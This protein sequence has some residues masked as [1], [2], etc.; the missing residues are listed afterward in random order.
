MTVGVLHGPNL[1]L[2][3]R[4][5]PETYGFEDLDSINRRIADAAAELDAESEFFQSNIEGELVDWIQRAEARLDGLLVNAGGYTHTSVAIRDALAAIS[6][7]F[8]EVHLTNVYA[9][10]PF[11]RH[12]HLSDIAVGLVVGFG[13][14]SYILA[15]QGLVA[16]LRRR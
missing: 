5:E 1:N 12:S 10:E 14:D 15:L 2:L 4:R 13:G 16:Y 6:I 7:P 8:V 9:R 11:R 3:G